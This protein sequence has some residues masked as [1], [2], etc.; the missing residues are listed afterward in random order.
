MIVPNLDNGQSQR[1]GTS[2]MNGLYLNGEHEG[3]VLLYFGDVRR[4]SPIY[5]RQ[6]KMIS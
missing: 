4:N 1:K 2:F 3:F 6:G 5:S